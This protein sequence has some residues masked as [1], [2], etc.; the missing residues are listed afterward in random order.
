[1][2]CEEAAEL[3]SAQLDGALTAEE[4]QALAHHLQGCPACRAVS[5]ELRAIHLAFETLEPIPAPEHLAGDVMAELE[6]A[7]VVP[8]FR[9]PAFK[10]AAG[11]AACL[12]LCVG[13]W[14][15]VSNQK[16]DIP[17]E[18]RAGV[19]ALEEPCTYTLSRLPQGTGLEGEDWFLDERGARCL[20]LSTEQ[21][22][23]VEQLAEEQGIV[24]RCSG[25]VRAQEDV[26]LVL[27]PE[28]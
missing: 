22:E 21:L 5:E 3:L 17:A 7:K 10:A 6:G 2:T 27:D 20:M 18:A 4:K 26:L 14:Q 13:L 12:V 23:T 11:L 1:M 8:L 16:Q 9:R 25:T 15:G 24:V 19:F 28:A